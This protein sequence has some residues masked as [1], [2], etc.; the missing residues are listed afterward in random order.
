M[1]LFSQAAQA[2]HDATPQAVTIVLVA[3]VAI[4]LVVEEVRRLIR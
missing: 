3:A 4:C 1:L 2:I